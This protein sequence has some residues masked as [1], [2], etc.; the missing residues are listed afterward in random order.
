MN[1]KKVALENELKRLDVSAKKMIETR[2]Y[3]K[4]VEKIRM[5]EELIREQLLN[6]NTLHTTRTAR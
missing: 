4:E 6:E 5:L 3:T 2:G 1:Q